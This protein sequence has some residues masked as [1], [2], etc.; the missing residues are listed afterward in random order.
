VSENLTPKHFL[1]R[2]WEWGSL[3]MAYNYRYDFWKL[4][5]E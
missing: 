3:G 4:R 2:G 5:D 1:N